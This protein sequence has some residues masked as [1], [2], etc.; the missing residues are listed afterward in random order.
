[1]DKKTI[2]ALILISV[3]I[4]LLPYYQ[5]L[6][7]GP[8]PAKKQ[9]VQQDSVKKETVVKE[10]E[11]PNVAKQVKTTSEKKVV[12]TSAQPG[13][14]KQLITDR[15]FTSDQDS[16]ERELEIETPKYHAVFSNLG[17][18]SIREFTLKKYKL[19]DSS[20]V[21]MIDQK[22]NN[23]L[24]LLFQNI[25]GDFVTT[26]DL[27]F[28]VNTKK[29]NVLLDENGDFSIQYS[30]RINGSELTKTYR[31][32]GDY[33]H[34]DVVVKFKNSEKILLN[35]RYQFGW[36]N[37]LPSTERY[38]ADD[39][40][41]NSAYVYIGDE[42]ERYEVKDPGKKEP[43]ILTGN[44]SWI[45]IRTKYFLESISNLNA[46]VSEGVILSGRGIKEKDYV[47][48]LY[49]ERY[50]IRYQTRATGDSLRIY[51]G[52]LD[53]KELSKY[54]NNLDVL[55]M[56]NGWYER[57]FRFF[58][59]PILSILELLHKV[60]PNYGIVI[61]IFSILVKLVLFP[62][63]KKSYTS[64]REMQRINPLI[65]ELKE[66]YKG[67]PQ[68]LNKEMMKLYKEHGV[69]PLG[70]CLPTLFQLPLLIALFIVFRSTIQLR[71]AVFIP[72]WINDL[73]QT[74]T[75]FTL[76]FSLPMYGNEFNL[77]PILMAV[78]MI[79]QSKMTMQDPKQKMM[80][81]LM[82]IFML[83][84]FN[85]FPSGLNLY[86]TLFNLLT[87]VQQKMIN[88]G[89]KDEPVL[90]TVKGSPPKTNVKRKKKK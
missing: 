63:T 11:Q 86:Y 33:Y 56:N 19:G 40:N 3:I 7:Y 89:V 36:K 46:D 72:G 17:G 70:G 23:G 65:A 5:E 13:E 18:G 85:R 73:S 12:E 44:A 27:L 58:S 34:F 39:Y 60:I 77:L 61:I 26:D 59:M 69:N 50:N 14:N 88:R 52:P 35:N 20:F 21:N 74:D 32:Y 9:V 67:D 4:L 47:R 76:P 37:G 6:V 75:L 87:I 29:R 8:Q 79:F 71:G 25:Q 90:A 43:E 38:V 57:T 48:R 54:D 10:K 62:F 80:V 78:T 83:L 31:F 84:I 66:K 51:L 81:Y 15:L 30:I 49:D 55:I 42:L 41:Y 82:P 68:R 45:G 1:M 16:V 53:H 24:N 28:H 22:V 2:L 64:M